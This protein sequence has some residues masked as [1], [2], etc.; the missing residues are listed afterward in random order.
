VESPDQPPQDR[1]RD[2]DPAAPR[3]PRQHEQPALQIRTLRSGARSG[4]VA[5][6]GRFTWVAGLVLAVSSFTSWY[7]GTSVE[8]PT[9]SVT[10]W[11]SGTLGKLVLLIGLAV[12]CLA[13][14]KAVGVAFPRS[15][16]EALIVLALGALATVFV[17]IR[18]ISIP[19][20][21][22]GTAGRGI[23]IWISLAA[24]TA[25]IVCG[26]LQAHEEL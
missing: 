17:L 26:L 6:G 21:L 3:A 18:L 5:V 20:D 7:S 13:L 24:A 9:I 14:M 25:V 15:A 22:A 16:P 10:G 11:N 4:I 19:A 2:T 12:I 1:P 8:G 23:G